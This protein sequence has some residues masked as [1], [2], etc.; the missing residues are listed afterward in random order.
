MVKIKRSFTEHKSTC[1][2][3][4]FSRL[5]PFEFW[6]FQ[7]QGLNGADGGAFTSRLL[8]KI[9]LLCR[10]FSIVVVNNSYPLFNSHILREGI[11]ENLRR[12][13]R[14]CEVQK[15]FLRKGKFNGK[16]FMHA[17]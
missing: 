13:G 2:I 7:S 1:V 16:K 9:L 3:V 15:K 8:V 10:K 14:G 5:S 12:G 17:N 6:K 4:F 11:L